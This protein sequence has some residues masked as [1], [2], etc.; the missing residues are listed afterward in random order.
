MLKMEILNLRK[1]WRIHLLKNKNV[2]C[3]IKIDVNIIN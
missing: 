3:Y 1:E 2:M